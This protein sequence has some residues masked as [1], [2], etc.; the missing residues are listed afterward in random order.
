MAKRRR[1]SKYYFKVGHRIR[2]AGIT[3]DLERREREHQQ[4]WPSGHIYKVGNVTTDG[5]AR[6]WEEQQMRISR[7]RRRKVHKGR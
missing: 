4:K 2:H 1:A 5:A 6:K 7:D 3:T